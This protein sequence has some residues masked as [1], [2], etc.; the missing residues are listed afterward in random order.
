MRPLSLPLDL[1]K[2]LLRLIGGLGYL[3]LDTAKAT[4][5]ALFSK[6]GRRMG[7]SNLWAQMDRVGVQSIP[8]V[9]LVLFC[10]GAILALQMAPTLDSFGLVSTIPDIIAVAV[11]RELG[12][13]VHE[14]TS[15]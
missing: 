13:L 6:R 7:W 9:S 3:L 15:P 10:I 12:P 14:L 2:N 8:I 4:R 1:A 5:L 11:Y